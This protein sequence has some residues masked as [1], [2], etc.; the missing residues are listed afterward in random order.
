MRQFILAL[1]ILTFFSSSVLAANVQ[2]EPN[3]A[4]LEINGA[5]CAYCA[6]GM[7]KGLSKMG[8]VDKSQGHNGIES[9]IENQIITIYLNEGDKIDLKAMADQIQKSG[10]EPRNFHMRVEG[11]SI[12]EGDKKFITDANNVKLYELIGATASKLENKENYDLQLLISEEAIKSLKNDEPP[13]AEVYA[14]VEGE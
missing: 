6:Y 10:Y 4:K 11:Q 2:V 14:I 1:T 9:D 12:V 7:Q 13:L 3:Q 5:V 8:C